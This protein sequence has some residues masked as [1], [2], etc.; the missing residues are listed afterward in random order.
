MIKNNYLHLPNL[1]GIPNNVQ[2]KIT[3]KITGSQPNL[4]TASHFQKVTVTTVQ[5]N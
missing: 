4:K 3:A 2:Q 5:S 1:S